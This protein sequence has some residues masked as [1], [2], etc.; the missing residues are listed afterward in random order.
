MHA[1]EETRGIESLG[2][3]IRGNYNLPDTGV[4][5][6]IHMPSTQTYILSTLR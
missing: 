5:N 4:G 3:E 6:Q 2:I 1:T